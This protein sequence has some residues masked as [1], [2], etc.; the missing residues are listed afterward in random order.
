MRKRAKE[1]KLA[2]TEE[3]R[4]AGLIKPRKGKVIA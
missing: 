4:Q 1:E 3:K 2:V